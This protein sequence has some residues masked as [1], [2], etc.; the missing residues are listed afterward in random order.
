MVPTAST[1]ASKP[2]IQNSQFSVNDDRDM[3]GKHHRHKETGLAD[4]RPVPK[5]TN[6]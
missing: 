5:S 2:L 4:M 6:C 3:V 1:A